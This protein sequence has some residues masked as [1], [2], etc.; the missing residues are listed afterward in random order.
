MSAQSRPIRV[1]VIGAGGMGTFHARTINAMPDAT[2]AALADPFAPHLND[3]ASELDA[4]TET[5][6][7][8][9]ITDDNIDA[10]IIASPDETHA[11][12]TLACL[13]RNKPV[14]CEKPLATSATDAKRV[15]QAEEAKGRRFIQLGFMREYDP[16]HLQLVAALGPLGAIH[17][18][19]CTHRN[20]PAPNRPIDVIIG[21]S[22]V[23]DIH[24]V[25]YLTGAEIAEVSASVTRQ[26]LGSPGGGIRHIIV[27]CRLTNGAHATLEFDNAAYAYEVTVDVTAVDGRA[28]TGRQLRAEVHTNGHRRIETGADWFARFADAYRLQDRAWI[29]S[30]LAGAPPTGP[31]AADGVAAQTVVEAIVAAADSGRTV[32]VDYGATTQS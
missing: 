4:T 27:L 16:A 23:H 26:P 31:S 8:K 6:P 22:V 32:A 3:L 5:D 11:E 7:S 30:V 19:H 9:V 24:S 12:L 17:H 29:D 21:Q 18:L 10:V 14:L 20:A 15:V 2:V 1:G 25:R 13:E 28:M